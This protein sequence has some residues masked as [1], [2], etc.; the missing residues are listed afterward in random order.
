MQFLEVA[1]LQPVSYEEI[2][3]RHENI[4]FPQ[5]IDIAH[6]SSIGFE[7]L[8]IAAFPYDAPRFTES[9]RQAPVLDNGVWKQTYVTTPIEDTLVDSTENGVTV[10]V[11]QQVASILT[12]GKVQLLNQLANYR[13]D[14]EVAGIDVNGSAIKTDRESQAT[15]NGAYTASLI[16]PSITINW[17]ASDGSWVSLDASAISTLAS[18]VITHVQSCFNKEKSIAE[19]INNSTTLAQ[20][21]AIDFDTLWAA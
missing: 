2:K 14:K 3:R 5:I 11:A 15:L 1:T 6:L 10:T 4:C 7:P 9:V 18:A 13:Y 19:A 12:E 17:K 16:N 21:R 8:E 20:L